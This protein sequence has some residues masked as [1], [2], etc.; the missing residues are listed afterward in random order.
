M[1]LCSKLSDFIFKYIYYYFMKIVCTRTHFL[2]L[3]VRSHLHVKRIF[4]KYE[5]REKEDM[6]LL[7]DTIKSLYE[8]SNNDILVFFHDT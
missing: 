5:K 2:P 3:I 8:Y 4:K 7:E 1:I 6:K